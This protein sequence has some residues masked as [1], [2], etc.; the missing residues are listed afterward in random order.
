MVLLGLTAADSSNP[1]GLK[2]SESS[3]TQAVKAALSLY[4]S[5]LHSVYKIENY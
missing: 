3:L 1:R 4:L 2:A 5:S